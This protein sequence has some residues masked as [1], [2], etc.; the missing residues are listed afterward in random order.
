MLIELYNIILSTVLKEGH[1][2]NS[3]VE[4]LKDDPN[5]GESCFDV[6]KALKE[7]YMDPSQKTTMI[8]YYS[9]NKKLD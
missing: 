3:I 2:F 9:S 8:E 7:W 4:K 1:A 6:W 5:I